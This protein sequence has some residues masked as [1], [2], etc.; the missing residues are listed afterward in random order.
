M[1]KKIKDITT[2]VRPDDFI[3]IQFSQLVD[4]LSDKVKVLDYRIEDAYKKEV[5]ESLY[6]TSAPPFRSAEEQ[7]GK[8]FK[9]IIE[10]IRSF[11]TE[12]LQE[13]EIAKSF[14]QP[15]NGEEK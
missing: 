5:I 11:H 10:D 3:H 8:F 1:L 6:K 4:L 15:T 14:N 9:P 7:L 13:S 12:V 2:P